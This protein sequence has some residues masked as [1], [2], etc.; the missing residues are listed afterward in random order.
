VEP[1]TNFVVCDHIK[2]LMANPVDKVGIKCRENFLERI[3]D[4]VRLDL[5]KEGLR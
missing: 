3:A 4:M 5:E 1:R 2:K